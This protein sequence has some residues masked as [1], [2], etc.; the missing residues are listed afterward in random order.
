MALSIVYNDQ[1]YLEYKYKKEEDYEND[2]FEKSSTFFGNKSV[3][4][5]SKKLIESTALGGTIPDGFLFDF[6]DKSNPNFYLIEVE[7]ATHDFYNHI[8]PQITK[9]FAFFKN[10]SSQ[11][12]LVEKLFNIINNDSKIKKQFQ[13]HIGE[14]EEIY[15]YL[16]DLIDSSQNILLIIDND[17]AEL[18]EIVDTYTDTWGKFVK[19]IR[20]KRYSSNDDVIFHMNPDFENIEFIESVPS[21]DEDIQFTEK[22]H[23]DNVETNVVEIFE[24]IKEKL[25]KYNSSVIFNPKKYYISVKLEKNIAYLWFRKK[26]IRILMMDSVE[27][28]SEKITKHEV[29]RLSESLQDVYNGL[30][31]A[32]DVDNTSHLDEVISYMIYLLENSVTKIE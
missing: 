5:N 32:V 21:K 31:A 16:S 12:N 1:K 9:F 15:K 8:F 13:K 10:P 17:K 11:K 4:I 19:I 30:C 23:L 29:F 6:A 28:L 2:I 25:E 20:I 18:P 7:L 3:L 22:Y 14:Q 24:E 27:K 26:K